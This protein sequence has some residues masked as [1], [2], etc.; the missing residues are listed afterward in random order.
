MKLK[1][2]ANLSQYYLTRLEI[3]IRVNLDK[4]VI[5]RSVYNIF[6]LLGDIGG[7]YGLFISIVTALLSVLNF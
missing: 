3:D 7:F 4:T 6:A 1:S 2:A 5:R